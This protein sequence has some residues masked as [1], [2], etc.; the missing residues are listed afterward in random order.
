MTF[1]FIY[2]QLKRFGHTPAKALEIIL[3][4]KRGDRFAFLW[5]KMVYRAR[6]KQ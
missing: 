5:I 6:H 1:P 3:D 2:R 4:A